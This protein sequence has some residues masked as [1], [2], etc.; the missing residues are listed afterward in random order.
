[1][2]R[3]TILMPSVL[4][5]AFVLVVNLALFNVK[6]VNAS[7]V[8]VGWGHLADG[9]DQDEKE[10]EDAVTAYII[11]YFNWAGW[12]NLDAYWDL[13]TEENVVYSLEWMQNPN[14]DV[15]WATTCG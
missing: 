2:K 3:K 6:P 1:M 13:T 12:D 4:V 10:C 7:Y 9:Y 5:F 8:G 14:N 15:D 11:D